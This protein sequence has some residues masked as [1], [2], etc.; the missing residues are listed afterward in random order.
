VGGVFFVGCWLGDAGCVLL[1]GF[2]WFLRCGVLV[3]LLGFFGVFFCCGWSLGGWL[4]VWVLWLSV[5][6]EVD[7]V[8]GLLGV[9]GGWCWGFFG[10]VFVGCVF[11]WSVVGC[12]GLVFGGGGGVLIWLSGSRFGWLCVGGVGGW[13]VCVC[14][15]DFGV[16]WFASGL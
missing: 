15:L 16:F 4:Y 12:A 13:L 2:C 10:L 1:G 6:G 11:V 9:G 8:F 14:L 5:L 7:M 3:C